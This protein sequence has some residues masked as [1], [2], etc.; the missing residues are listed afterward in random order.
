MIPGGRLSLICEWL[1]ATQ[2]HGSGGQATKTAACTGTFRWGVNGGRF[3]VWREQTAFALYAGTGAPPDPFFTQ[4]QGLGL[5][6]LHPEGIR[7]HSATATTSPA[8][9]PHAPGRVSCGWTTSGSAP[10][11]LGATGV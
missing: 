2:M 4:G 8:A 11:V 5:S 10:P 7:Q 9:P 3:D 1:A 6:P